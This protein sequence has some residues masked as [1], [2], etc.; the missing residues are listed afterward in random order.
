MQRVRAIV[1]ALPEP[2]SGRTRFLVGTAQKNGRQFD[3]PAVYA[4]QLPTELT[5]VRHRV[6]HRH[7]AIRHRHETRFRL[8]R[9]RWRY[10]AC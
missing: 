4:F 3:L 1:E 8:Y 2:K 6:S 7:R 5:C 9:E 10:R